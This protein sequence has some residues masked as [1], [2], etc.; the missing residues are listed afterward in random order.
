MS[1]TFR[2]IGPRVLVSKIEMPALKSA[3]IEVVQSDPPPSRYAMVVS[4]GQ[5]RFAD[6]RERT[7]DFAPGDVVVIKEYCGAPVTVDGKDLHMLVEDDVLA[8]VEVT[9]AS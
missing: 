6:G 4:L 9:S 5:F 1:D 3:L 2:P 7:L 8:V